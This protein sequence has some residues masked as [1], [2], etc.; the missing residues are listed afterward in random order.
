MLVTVL[1]IGSVLFGLVLLA[2]GGVLLLK[3]SNKL[4][5]ILT[6]AAGLLFTVTPLLIFLAL[7]VVRTTTG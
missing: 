7:T 5:G 3:L 6:I 4:P 1:L 2:V